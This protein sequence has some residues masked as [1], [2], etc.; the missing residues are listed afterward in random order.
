MGRKKTS[1]GTN[2]IEIVLEIRCALST[3]KQAKRNPTSKLPVS[4]INI[5]AG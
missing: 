4:P 1:A 5:L 2:K 3:E